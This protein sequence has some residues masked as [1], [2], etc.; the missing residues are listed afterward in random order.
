MA[1]LVEAFNT[2]IGDEGVASATVPLILR[3]PA[4]ALEQIRHLTLDRPL[5]PVMTAQRKELLGRFA[6]GIDLPKE[7]FD[8]ADLNHWTAWAVS[9][10]T[11]SDHV[12][13]HIVNCVDALTIGYFRAALMIDSRCQGPN[14]VWISRL[15]VWYDPTELLSDP[16]E[17]PNATAAHAAIAIS[18]A[19]YR[20]RL[21]FSEADAPSAQEIELRMVRTVRS[22]PPNTLEALLH[23]LDPNLVIPPIGQSGTIP[24]MGPKGAVPVPPAV[25]PGGA[26]TPAGPS[27]TPPS[28]APPAVQ[29]PPVGTGPSAQP[30]SNPGG[31]APVN[32]SA[33]PKPTADQARLSRKL[34]DIDRDVRRSLQIAA[35]ASIRRSL[36][37]AGA[38]LR[39]NAHNAKD[40]ETMS[41]LT[42]VPAEQV[43]YVMGAEKV[44][45]FGGTATVSSD[46]SDVKQAYESWVTAA[47]E[48]AIAVAQQLGGSAVSPTSVAA[49]RSK[50]TEHRQLGWEALSKALDVLAVKALQAP[51]GITAALVPPVPPV[52]SKL[53]IPP[54]LVSAPS[55]AADTDTAIYVT[56]DPSTLA[57]TST[58]RAVLAIAGGMAAADSPIN[59]DTGT[60]DALSAESVLPQIGTGVG[61]SDLLQEANMS[62]PG[63]QWIHGTAAHDFDPHVELDGVEF[64]SFDDPVLATDGSGTA[65]PSDWLGDFYCPGDHDGCTCDFMPL[66]AASDVGDRPI[67][68]VDT[69]D[70]DEDDAAVAASAVEQ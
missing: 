17:V 36:E 30:D 35:S 25:G 57:P 16:N 54:E 5:D 51:P 48:Q 68:Q 61:I 19:A 11:F 60:V 50:L 69:G 26:P 6:N 1:K 37:K 58:I 7:L 12:E 3:G 27:A 28:P 38:K 64:S 22:Y 33:A 70:S 65:D 13:P 67:D 9:A 23:M 56:I 45:R 18:D 34:V 31:G 2:G 43:A 59:P 32:A 39:T 52:G 47:Q 4:T 49:L 40:R 24:G 62:T 15:C 44:A 46:W 10:D 21:G 8:M 29:G 20:K 55:D 41:A 42:G 63:Y 14:A 53:V 66:W